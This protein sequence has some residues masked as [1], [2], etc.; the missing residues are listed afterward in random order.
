MLHWAGLSLFALLVSNVQV[1]TRL[2]AAS[3]P[4]FYWHMA[5]LLDDPRAPRVSRLICAYV[6]GYAVC[7][8]ALHANFFP[9]T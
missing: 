5:T 6:L 2:V 7:G 8:T 3:C 4:P 9:W 1:A